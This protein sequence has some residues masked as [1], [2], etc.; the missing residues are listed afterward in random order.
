MFSQPLLHS[1]SIVYQS[2]CVC[3]RVCTYVALSWSLS[4]FSSSAMAARLISFHGSQSSPHNPSSLINTSRSRSR[5]RSRSFHAHHLSFSGVSDLASLS[6][7]L[8]LE[9]QNL[10]NWNLRSQDLPSRF[11]CRARTQNDEAKFE[12]EEEEEEEDGEE[13]RR[14]R[15]FVSVFLYVLAGVYILWLFVLPYAPVSQCCVQLNY[16]TETVVIWISQ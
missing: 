12:A 2:Y 8:N 6:P 1:S 15:S 4:V 3:I 9:R 7:R 11:H 14:K 13:S 5:S 10:G 16:K